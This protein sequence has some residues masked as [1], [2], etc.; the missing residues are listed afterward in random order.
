[1]AESKARSWAVVGAIAHARQS[2]PISVFR[3]RGPAILDYSTVKLKKYRK[4]IVDS[5]WTDDSQKATEPD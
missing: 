2:R 3:V 5:W 4:S 1:M